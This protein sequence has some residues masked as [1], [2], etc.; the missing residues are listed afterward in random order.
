[1]RSTNCL[2]RTGLAL[3]VFISVH[4]FYGG[5]SIQ[6]EWIQFRNEVNHELNKNRTSYGEDLSILKQHG[7]FALSELQS[8]SEVIQ[9]LT[10]QI[11]QM[12]GQIAQLEQKNSTLKDKLDTATTKFRMLVEEEGTA[13]RKADQDIIHEIS[14]EL[15][16]VTK[17]IRSKPPPAAAHVVT[18]GSYHLYEVVKGD[19]L[20]A[21]AVA[22]SIPLQRLKTFN[23]LSND[24]IIVGQKLKI[25]ER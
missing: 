3:A 14:G 18:T 23:K 9:D 24:T 15:S 1:M 10:I 17:K 12:K 8:L 22:F 5:E 7:N 21:I 20:G 2:I 19:T 25:P 11:S 6:D 16:R 4:C 13:R